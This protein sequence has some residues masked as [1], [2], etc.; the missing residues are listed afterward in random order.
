MPS[1]TEWSRYR[2]A[3]YGLLAVLVVLVTIPGYLI[4]EPSWR[5]VAVRLA[6]AVIVV[7]GSTRVV[8]AVRRS[9]EGHLP[10]ALDAPPPA[11]RRPT[12]DERF[13]RVR[14]DLVF[15]TRSRR[16]FDVF[17]WPRLRT[18]GG[19]DVPP[20]VERRGTRR[21]GPSLSALDRLIAE[22]ERRQ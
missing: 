2:L 6:C 10:S 15:S 19:A 12:L 4:L 7:I 5:P 22:I 9:I 16:Y 13:L 8:G 18:L 3:V 14:D 21:G 1:H 17:L 20:P 11:P